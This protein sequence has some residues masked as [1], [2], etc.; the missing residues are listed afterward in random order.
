MEKRT[1]APRPI[2]NVAKYLRS[3]SSGLKNR[4]G[5]LNGKRVDYFKG[6]SAVKAL[7]KESYGKLK[8]VPKVTSENEACEVL[9]E[10]L[11]H[12][13]FLRVERS[14]SENGSRNKSLNVTSTQSWGKDQYYVWFYEGSQLMTI[15]GGI[16]L[17]SI[18]FAAV[19]FPLWPPILRDT[20]WYLSVAILSL[21]GVFMAL[22]VIRLIL[23]I[24]TMI[25]IPPGIWLFPNLFED[26]GFIDS[27][28]PLWAWEVPKKKDKVHEDE[29][30]AGGSQNP[31]RDLRTTVE[32][33]DEEEIYE[34]GNKKE[35]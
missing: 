31:N 12:A 11:R 4:Q 29:D 9:Q 8:E 32:D 7:L 28:I 19:L 20:V 26:V 35:N 33:G 10:V 14:G 23:F 22:A 2:L 27:F 25:I 6:K 17:I 16:G 21:F 1:E 34:D 24:I 5:V 18:V 13:F 30:E 3:S 15:L